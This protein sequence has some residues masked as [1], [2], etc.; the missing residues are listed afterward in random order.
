MKFKTIAHTIT[1]LIIIASNIANA[2]Q[3]EV[4][5]EA[6]LNNFPSSPII[7]RQENELLSCKTDTPVYE[8]IIS[9]MNTPAKTEKHFPESLEYLN[10]A[11]EATYDT[12]RNGVISHVTMKVALSL[13]NL[14]VDGFAPEN[15]ATYVSDGTKPFLPFEFANGV[16]IT[17]VTS[18]G[19][20]IIYRA[21]M[22]ITKNHSHA[23]PLALAG[24]VSATTTICND[25]EMLDDL[26]GRNIVIQYDYYDANGVFFSSF[27]ING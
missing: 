10:D 9:S 23:A 15:I 21:E 11:V 7:N 20:T 2:G 5:A 6:T 12:M 3:T 17:K 4:T 1:L 16:K 13:F 25:T 27:T 18:K 26:L 22:P 8:H 24:R 14:S 19:G